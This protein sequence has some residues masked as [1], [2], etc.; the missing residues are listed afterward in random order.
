MTMPINEHVFM[1]SNS[2]ILQDIGNDKGPKKKLVAFGY[3]G[4]SP[5]QLEDELQRRVW[6]TTPGD[7]K[8]IFDEDRE[9]LWDT[10]YARRT[11]D[12]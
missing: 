2:Q 5:H 1:T 9:K 11:Q 6:F 8:L 7:E 3:A 12:L 10:A 4:W